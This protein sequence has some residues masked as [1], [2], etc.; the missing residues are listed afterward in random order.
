MINGKKY[1]R[2][3]DTLDTFVDSSWY[4]LRFCS[5]DNKNYGF[6]YEDL[7][8]WMPVDQYIGGIEHAILH[9]LYSRFFMQAISFENNDFKY[10]EPFDGLFT[11]GMVCHETYKDQ[12]GKWLG[13]DQINSEDGKNYFDNINGS[14]VIVGPS[15]SMSKSKK[16][17]VDPE[18]VIKNYGADSIRWFILSDS[19]PNKDI[20]WSDVGI[21]TSYK[22][23]QKFWNL[24][25]NIINR[26]ET[27][28][29]QEDEKVEKFTNKMIFNVTKNLENFQYNVVVANFYETYNFFSKFLINNNI[30]N[31]II[32]KNFE[33]ILILISPI[34]PHLANE[35]INKINT[36]I[37]L[38]NL[39]WPEI[40]LSK[41]EEDDCKIVV[42]INGK[43][44]DLI[45]L[46]KN[47]SENEVVDKIISDEKLN[48]YLHNV[49]IKKQIY[50]K[51]KLINFII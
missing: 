19:P 49:K 45:I 2:E 40:D 46:P 6:S 24:N 26:K 28:N 22:F 31:K 36:K 9:L 11:Q 51:D 27:K 48:K 23:V 20:Q 3:T 37:N 15:E 10:T 13:L 43:K 30:S 39:I 38:D 50:I 5:P 18:N 12:D 21:A 44:R 16:N 34:L 29:N 32:I 17:T 41:I 35:C 4:F 8:Y 25:F 7:K 14:K 1:T 47:T 33:K 42:Q